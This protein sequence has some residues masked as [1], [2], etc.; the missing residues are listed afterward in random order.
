MSRF[1]GRANRGRDKVASRRR[2]AICRYSSKRYLRK[3]ST[4]DVCVRLSNRSRKGK[5]ACRSY[6]HS[7]PVGG[8]K[9][10]RSSRP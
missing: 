8:R 2:Q 3:R 4:K 5:D 1:A 6:R 7:R 9:K 10:T